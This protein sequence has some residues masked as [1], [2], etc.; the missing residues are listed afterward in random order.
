MQIRP[1]DQFKPLA[2]ALVSAL[3][4]AACSESQQSAP[5][6]AAPSVGVVVAETAS[7][8]LINEL[9]GRTAPYMVAELRPQVTG[10]VQ[11]RL[12]AEGS[13]VKA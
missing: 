11:K 4:L 9:P 7:V 13:E 10:I 3:L 8:P 12:F 2:V 5:A 1:L 6:P